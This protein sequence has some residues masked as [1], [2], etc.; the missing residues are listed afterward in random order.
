MAGLRVANV[1]LM[2]RRLDISQAVVEVDAGRHSW[3][4]PKNHERR[5]V[6]IPHFLVDELA[7]HRHGH[8]FD[9]LVFTSPIGGV[10]RNKNARRDWFNAAV[11]AIGEPGFVPH[12]LRHTAASL[13]VPRRPRCCI[14]DRWRRRPAPRRTTG[15]P[16]VP[17]QVDVVCARPCPLPG[18]DATRNLR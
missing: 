2:R 1:K 15:P 4:S 3:N 5:S 10:L 8:G 9:D 12:E 11:A 17:Q 14:Q 16:Q 13:A 7:V 6:P 18:W